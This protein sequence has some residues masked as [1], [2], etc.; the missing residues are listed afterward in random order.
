LWSISATLFSS[1]RL[2]SHQSHDL[3][4]SHNLLNQI[5]LFQ[6]RR[7]PITVVCALFESNVI[8]PNLQQSY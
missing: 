7:D 8:D 4:Q 3:N 1:D 5:R 2:M 6:M